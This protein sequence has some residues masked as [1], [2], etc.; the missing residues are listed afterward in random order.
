MKRILLLALAAAIV[1]A[2]PASHLL[3]AKGHVP[4]GK[5]QVCH[6]GSVL[7]IGES[8]VQDHLEHGDCFI[9][10]RTQVP[11]SSRAILAIAI[12]RV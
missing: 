6:K 3:F 2:I 10:K 5:E 1:L 11:L 7:V 12:K 9:D 4:A 8:S